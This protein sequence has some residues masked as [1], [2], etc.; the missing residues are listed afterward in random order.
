MVSSP[1]IPRKPPNNRNK[2]CVFF[3]YYNTKSHLSV[4]F[5]I[6]YKQ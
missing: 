2:L 6:E 3:F 5:E 4:N 1:F